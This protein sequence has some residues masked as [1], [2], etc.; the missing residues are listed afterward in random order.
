MSY[1]SKVAV[2]LL[3]NGKSPKKIAGLSLIELLLVITVLATISVVG[4]NFWARTA[5]DQKIATTVQQFQS[6]MLTERNYYQSRGT[7]PDLANL[8]DFYTFAPGM[9]YIV[10]NPWGI[11]YKIIDSTFQE[12]LSPQTMSTTVPTLLS[13]IHIYSD[14]RTTP[15]SSLSRS[16]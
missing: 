1:L 2:L 14:W 13:L 6:L 7:W 9:Q 5:E 8:T 10:T 15:I 11:A 16:K 3:L 4:I 12:S